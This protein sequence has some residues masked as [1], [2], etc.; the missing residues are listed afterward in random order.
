MSVRT[1]TP[2]GFAVTGAPGE[3]GPCAAISVPK[4]YDFTGGRTPE[5]PE[6]ERPYVRRDL[7][8]MEGGALPRPPLLDFTR[9][10]R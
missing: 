3:R 10:G 9:R 7:R 1:R 6:A 4:V 8:P 5:I 2:Y